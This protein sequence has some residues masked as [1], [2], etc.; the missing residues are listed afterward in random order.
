MLVP[1]QESIVQNAKRP[2][3]DSKV[4]SSFL[5]PF[6]PGVEIPQ[7]I[8]LHVDPETIEAITYALPDLVPAEALSA[9]APN[10]Y[11]SRRGAMTRFYIT[12]AGISYRGALERV[13]VTAKDDGWI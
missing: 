5:P 2:F 7:A 4:Q 6:V 3:N 12:L 8:Y 11:Q 1:R 9:A 13:V 10:V